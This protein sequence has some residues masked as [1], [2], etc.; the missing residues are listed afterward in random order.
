MAPFSLINRQFTGLTR[1]GNHLSMKSKYLV[2]F[3][4]LIALVG[5]S[6]NAQAQTLAT[7]VTNT[8]ATNPADGV[9]IA[10]TAQFSIPTNGTLVISLKNVSTSTITRADLLSGIFFN[11]T[12]NSADP[13]DGLISTAALGSGS[14]V[15]KSDNATATV[16]ADQIVSNQFYFKDVSGVTGTAFRYGINATGFS[17]TTNPN[18]AFPNP[19]ASGDNYTIVPT[20]FQSGGIGKNN[21]VNVIKN[22]VVLTLTGFTNLTST[23]QVS[24]VGFA[25]GSGAQVVGGVTTNVIL[26]GTRT[27][28]PGA[29]SLLA[30][31]TVAGSAFIR[32]RR[33]RR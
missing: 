29:L 1:F 12:G 14:T 17:S 4:I 8:G 22:E 27:P 3:P 23:S 31:M 10:F 16:A 13:A 5:A 2:P 20:P 24:N 32:Q 30:G 33:K 21:V 26:Q 9:P 28:E 6:L 19:G 15:V 25:V 7:Y 11:I 18:Y